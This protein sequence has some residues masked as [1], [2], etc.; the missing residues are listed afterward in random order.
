MQKDL[1]GNVN[2]PIPKTEGIKYA[3]SKLKIIPHILDIADNLSFES[4][5]D[6]FSGTTRVAQAFAQRGKLTTANDISE[7]SEVFAT[8]YLLSQKEDSFYQ[9]YL[10]LLNSL[11]GKHGWFTEHYGGDEKNAK[12]PFQRHFINTVLLRH[13][14]QPFCHLKLQP[15]Y[16]L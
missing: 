16:A 4:V 12:R 5:L 11:K 7:W 6:G 3:G 10:D 2:L 8:C 9:P 1:F 13:K 14:A 15:I